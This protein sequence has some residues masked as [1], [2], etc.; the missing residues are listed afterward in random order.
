MFHEDEIETP[1]PDFSTVESTRKALSDV[2][3]AAKS[4]RDANGKLRGDLEAMKTDLV[5]ANQALAELQRAPAP[6]SDGPDS[7]LRSFVRDDGKVRAVGE[8]SEQ[9]G[10]V[11]GLLDSEPVCAWQKELQDLVETRNIVRR[12]RTGSEDR[13]SV[14]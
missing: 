6:A 3:I 9:E 13:K 1:E 12:I 11:P 2:H 5:R 8:L 4:L 10:W 7:M 14:V